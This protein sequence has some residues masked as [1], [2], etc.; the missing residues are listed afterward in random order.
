MSASVTVTKLS[1][2]GET[3]Y[4]W[5]GE[6]VARGPGYVTL[7]A[8]W[9]GPGT[10]RVAEDVVF[11]RGDVFYEYY[12]DSK[13]YGLWQVLTP[14]ERT[15]KCWYC[16]ISTPAHVSDDTITF[17]DLLLDVLL[18]PD[19][20]CRVLDREEL[21]RARAEGLDPALAALAEEGARAVLDLIATGRPPFGGERMQSSKRPTPG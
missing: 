8:V 11:E 1:W 19:G 17:R 5:E 6:A 10:V 12:D 7:R 14:D 2:R 13:P 3:V 16:N 20:T 9:Q 15:L 4:S 18:L 21:A